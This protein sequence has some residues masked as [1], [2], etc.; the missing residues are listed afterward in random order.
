ME[1]VDEADLLKTDGSYIYTIS[2]NQ[3]SIIRSFPVNNAQVLSTINL[4]TFKPEAIFIEGDFL[5]VFGTDYSNYNFYYPGIPLN[6]YKYTTIRV[7][8]VQNRANPF[9]IKEFKIEGSYF[10]GRK[11][12][13]G[14]IYVL[15]KQLVTKRINPSPWYDLNGQQIFI[16]WG[17]IFYYPII[18]TKPAFVNIFAFNLRNPYSNQFKVVSLVSENAQQLYMSEKHIYITFPNKQFGQ[19]YTKI[20][21]VFVWRTI[22]VPFADGNILGSVDS[23]FWMDEFGP[24]L[25]VAAIVNNGA[26]NRVYCLNYHLN[27]YGLL[28]NIAP[29]ERITAARYVGRR[30][31]LVTF[32][33]T[34]P[35]FVIG[36][37]DHRFPV[38]LGELK[39][40]GFSKYLHPYD[41]KTIIGLGRQATV[42]GRPLGLKLAL[43]DVSNV[44]SPKEITSFELQETYASSEAE[45]EHKAFL[46][47]RERNLLVIPG[48]LNSAQ[49]KFNGAFVFYIDRTQITLKSIVDHIKTPQD[50]FESRT[51]QRSLYIENFLYCKSKCLL[52]ISSLFD[53]T[54]VRDID[55]P[56]ATIP[57]PSNPIIV[58]PPIF[59]PQPFPNIGF[60]PGFVINNQ[61]IITF[62]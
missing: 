37:N 36:F 8:N 13:D 50:N 52:S 31:Y 54:R 2:G 7:Y 28:N 26:Y 39:I 47:S 19:Q 41:E 49:A 24:F 17:S 30:L 57:Q 55:I 45:T 61:G 20:H 42:N 25:R 29:G 3:L 4:G 16:G 15:S 40:S 60:N 59:Q 35:F 56:C 62:P 38:I 46:F 22:I 27:P 14:F 33:Q 21:K 5:A 12:Q 9:K 23:Q 32:R 53:Y 48:K 43:F 10:N 6:Q 44:W 58:A 11:T 18:Y 1:A 51:V 34:D